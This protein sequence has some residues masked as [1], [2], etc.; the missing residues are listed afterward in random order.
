MKH[1][2]LLLSLLG[3]LNV[4]GPAMAERGARDGNARDAGQ[5]QQ[6]RQ[7]RYVRQ[8]D[9]QRRNEDRHREQLSPEQREQ[10][11]RDISDHGREIYRERRDRR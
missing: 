10:L 11:K 5:G 2:I 6:Q 8:D 3:A 7:D 9:Y 4:V 1:L